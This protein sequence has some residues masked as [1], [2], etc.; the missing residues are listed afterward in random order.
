MNLSRRSLLSGL[1]AAPAVILTPGLLM[2]IKPWIVPVT[3][4]AAGDGWV[5]PFRYM[6][7]NGKMYELVYGTQEDGVAIW[8]EIAP[9]PLLV[10]DR[11][12]A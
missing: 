7:A 12:R 8:K 2:P 4:K 3:F 11:R 5:G 1:I 9:S 10:A 6:L